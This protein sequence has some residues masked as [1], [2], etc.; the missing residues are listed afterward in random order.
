MWKLTLLSRWLV[1]AFAAVV[2][3]AAVSFIDDFVATTPNGL[4]QFVLLAGGLDWN[5]RDSQVPQF[6]FEQGKPEGMRMLG[7]AIETV[8][9]IAL[10][11]GGTYR[12]V[13]IPLWPLLLVIAIRP[14]IEIYR[15][16]REAL[17]ERRRAAGQC[18]YCGYDLRAS[19][20]RCPECGRS[21]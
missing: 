21:D 5:H 7:F 10:G 19:G 16:R 11:V 2:I 8:P 17:R 14:A 3:I 9:T 12:R 18:A 13:S 1:L 20:E 4:N 6:F 15:I